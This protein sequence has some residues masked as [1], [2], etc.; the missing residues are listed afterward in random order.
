MRSTRLWQKAD[1]FRRIPKDLTESTAIGA[2][3]SIACVV[4][5][6]LLFVGEVISYVSPRI[7]SDMVIMPDL[8][9]ESIIKV[10]LDLTFHKMPCSILTLDILDV[11]HNHVF[12]SMEHITKTRL[13]AEG[14]PVTDGRSPEEFVSNRE[15][16]NLRGYIQVAK[17]PGNFHI[18]SHGRQQLLNDH[19]K[20]GINVEH[21]IHHLSFGS[22]DVMKFSKQAQ[23]HP[24]DGMTQRSHLPKLFQYYL[25]IVPTIYEGAF[26]TT[27]TYQFTGTSSAVI[28]PTNQMPAVVFQY[29]LSPITVRYSAARVS[30]TH[31]LTYVCAI[32][33]G[34]FT[35]AGLLS[36]FVQTSAAQI[37]RRILG[38]AD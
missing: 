19:F 24:L 1:F 38:K 6:V 21:T 20:A 5:M 15:G 10:S 35:V 22:T 26:S 37:Q 17:V 2:I 13:D 7:Q 23:L 8:D 36:R 28:L 12:N 3:I 4:V 14:R 18:S 27:Y 30:F 33:G 29:Q 32:V 9:S 31:F 16:C 11:L 34:V 25:D